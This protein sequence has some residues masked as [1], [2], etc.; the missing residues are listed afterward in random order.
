MTEFWNSNITEA[1]W[2]GLQELNKEIDFVLIGGWATY[3]YTRLQK[4]KDIDVVVDYGTLRRLE[5]SYR[6]IKNE[7]LRKYEIKKEKYDIDIYLPNYSKLALKPNDI[8]SKYRDSLGG[9]HVPIPEALMAL[10]LGA[11]ADRGGSAKGEKDA[12]DILGL[13]FYSRM[14]LPRLNSVLAE[15]GMQERLRLLLS[16]LGNFDRRDLG[17]LNL[18]ESSFSKLKREHSEGIRKLL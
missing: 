8:L 16:I 14:D 5:G 12:I 18:N 1:S 6:L 11:A 2:L 10:K 17:Y 9:F 7:R 3:L 15:N 4:S 13:L